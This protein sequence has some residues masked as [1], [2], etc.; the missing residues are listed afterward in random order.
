MSVQIKRAIDPM[1]E[2]MRLADMRRLQRKMKGVKLQYLADET[3][4]FDDVAGISAA[5][6][7]IFPCSCIS[8]KQGWLSVANLQL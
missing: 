3:V 2:E 5:K 8:A 6:V 1:S 7:M 4:F